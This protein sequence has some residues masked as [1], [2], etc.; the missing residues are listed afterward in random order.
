M[1][2]VA[3][4]IVGATVMPH[5]LYLHSALVQTRELRA[6]DASRRAAIRWNTVDVVV[7]LGLAF[8][9]NAAILVLAAATF[10]GRAGVTAGGAVY[11]FNAD[12]D[13]IRV[14]Y[15]TLTPLLGAGAASLLFAVAL[16]ASGQSS[17]ITGTLAG[18]GRVWADIA[19]A[20]LVRAAIRASRMS[21][22]AL[23]RVVLALQLP[24]AMFPLLHLTSRRGVMGRWR[25]G[26]FLLCAGWGGA[27]LITAMDLYGLPGALGDTVRA[28]TGR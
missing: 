11:A 19:R 12:T 9:V 6:D 21:A 5:N 13:W 1:A 24:F 16:L 4:G 14:A 7:A 26:W 18:Q 17:T 20:A 23:S 22:G 10:H 27:A 28:F 15:L 2:T 3:V 8:F 25:N